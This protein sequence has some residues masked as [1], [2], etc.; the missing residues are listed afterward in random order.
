MVRKVR[1]VIVPLNPTLLRIF[2]LNISAQ[3]HSR[4]V[5]WKM[6]CTVGRQHLISLRAHRQGLLL[7]GIGGTFSKFLVLNLKMLMVILIL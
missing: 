7:F 6:E 3:Q 2:V 5:I 1:A 4:E